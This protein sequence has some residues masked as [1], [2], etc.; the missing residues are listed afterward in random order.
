MGLAVASLLVIFTYV[1]QPQLPA[2]LSTNSW[3]Y[4]GFIAVCTAIGTI[5]L[6]SKKQR[7]PAFLL[8]SC[9]IIALLAG[10]HQRIFAGAPL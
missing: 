7:W 2:I 8:S 5:F 9:T 4:A 6:I 1:I 3:I 10:G